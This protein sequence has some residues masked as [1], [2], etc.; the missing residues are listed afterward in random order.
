MNVK[1]CQKCISLFYNAIS[2]Y[3][4]SLDEKLLHEIIII[5]I[6][7]QSNQGAL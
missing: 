5:I 3:E 4:I 6:I 2:P 1:K 7:I